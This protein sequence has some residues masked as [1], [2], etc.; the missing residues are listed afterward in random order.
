[1]QKLRATAAKIREAKALRILESQT[2]QGVSGRQ[3]EKELGKLGLPVDA[4]DVVNRSRSRKN[5]AS[6]RREASASLARSKS[7]HEAAVARSTR[8]RAR[9]GVRDAAME[10]QVV[11]RAKVDSARLN[12]AKARKDILRGTY[13]LELRRHK[14]SISKA[15]AR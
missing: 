13:G 12:G 3:M 11:R 8:P 14:T 5:A 7:L 2:E 15:R 10:A 1:M 6:R 9:S 4:S